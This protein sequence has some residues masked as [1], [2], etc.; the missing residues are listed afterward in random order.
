VDLAL[1]EQDVG[2]GV[3]AGGARA[4][5]LGVRL[6]RLADG[7]V[8]GCGDGS[9]AVD[10]VEG[11]GAVERVLQRRLDAV[12]V[13]RRLPCVRGAGV[14]H[15]DGASEQARRGDQRART[16]KRSAEPRPHG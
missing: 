9:A 7:G 16:T 5:R 15:D 2:V 12:Q 11:H 8:D 10:R 6:E 14:E 3:R 1:A 13:R 4:V